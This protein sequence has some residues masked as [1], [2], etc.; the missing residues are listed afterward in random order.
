MGRIFIPTI[1]WSSES[2]GNLGF[3]VHVVMVAY[4]FGC[5]K[6]WYVRFGSNAGMFCNVCMCVCV[7]MDVCML[8][9]LWRCLCLHCKFGF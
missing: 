9:I 7:C 2:L 1:S 3:H 8:L 5:F 6:M 4:V